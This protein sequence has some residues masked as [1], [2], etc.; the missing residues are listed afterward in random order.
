MSFSPTN[1]LVFSESADAKNTNL[2]A[3]N[4]NIETVAFPVDDANESG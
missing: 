2:P 1:A 4:T 3:P